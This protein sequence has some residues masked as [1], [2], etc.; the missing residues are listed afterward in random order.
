MSISKN[1]DHVFLV[2][3]HVM[4]QLTNPYHEK[5]AMTNMTSTNLPLGKTC[6]SRTRSFSE[7]GLVYSWE[8][9]V[10]PPKLPPPINKALFRD[11]QPLVSLNKALLGPY[12]LGDT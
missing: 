12:L 1:N 7:G 5:F 3:M 9:K 10:P 4:L 6:Q 8:P 2:K 11:Y